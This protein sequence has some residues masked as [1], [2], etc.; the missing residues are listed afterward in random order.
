MISAQTEVV[1][2]VD[3]DFLAARDLPPCYVRQFADA[4]RIA[5]GRTTENPRAMD[6]MVR[7]YHLGS[8]PTPTSAKA[9][10]AL[11]A[12]PSSI[13]HLLL[14]V[15]GRLGVDV[16]ESESREADEASEKWISN[17]VEDLQAAGGQGLVV[18]GREQPAAV[19]AIAHAINEHL[20]AVGKTIQYVHSPQVRP[21]RSSSD[22]AMLDELTAEMR[23]GKV[24]T[25]VDS[26]RESRVRRAA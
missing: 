10:H 6:S 25:L 17:V 22:V 20:Q 13:G 15:A 9:D 1:L 24:D 11:A 26:R 16:G 14:R 21:D 2:S 5:G 23:D 12:A 18:V 7:L 4:R 3:C 19:H 8:T